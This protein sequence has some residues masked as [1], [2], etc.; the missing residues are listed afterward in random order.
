MKLAPG[1]HVNWVRSRFDTLPGRCPE[2]FRLIHYKAA[3][4]HLERDGD[5]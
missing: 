2:L 1:A 5:G 3:A 4:A